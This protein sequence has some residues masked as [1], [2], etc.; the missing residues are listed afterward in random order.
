MG[1]SLE[2]R[3]AQVYWFHVSKLLF[4]KKQFNL[5]LCRGIKLKL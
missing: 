2:G 1:G 3:E 5:S 4:K